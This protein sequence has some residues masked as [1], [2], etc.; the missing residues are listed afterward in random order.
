MI[1]FSIVFDL[2]N[3]ILSFTALFICRTLT[4]RLS[5]TK[6]R[7][8]NVTF[9]ILSANLCKVFRLS[10]KGRELSQVRTSAVSNRVPESYLSNDKILSKCTNFKHRAF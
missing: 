6:D 7:R 3:E 4:L 8:L 1:Y 9:E 10:K 2:H 5:K